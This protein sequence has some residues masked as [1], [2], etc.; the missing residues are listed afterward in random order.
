M[1]MGKAQKKETKVV[2][3]DFQARVK[4]FEAAL[5]G[6]IKE[7]KVGLRPE[8]SADRLKIA[9]VL[10]YIDLVELEKQ[11]NGEDKK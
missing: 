8:L 9:A 2:G 11:Q 7:H 6:L 10:N 3:N 4:L 5:I 1:N